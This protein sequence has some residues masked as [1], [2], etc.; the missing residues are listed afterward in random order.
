MI[1]KTKLIKIIW[2]GNFKISLILPAP[3]YCEIIAE[4]ADRVCAKTQ[5]IVIINEPAMPTAAKDSV[6]FIFKLPTIA[7]SVIDK[8]GSA[9]PA[10]IAG[11]ANWFI[12]LN[13][14]EDLLVN[15]QDVYN[16]ENKTLKVVNWYCISHVES[17]LFAC[18]FFIVLD[19]RNNYREYKRRFYY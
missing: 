17:Q 5:T 18:S 13:E 6:G 16:R 11:I 14:N 3:R 12:L 2:E 1:L 19:F 10:I 9:M 7:V 4:I 15:I 8:R